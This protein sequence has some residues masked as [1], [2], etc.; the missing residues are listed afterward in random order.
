M[1]DLPYV[2]SPFAASI[3]LPKLAVA[4]GGLWN[5][6]VHI[7]PDDP[8]WEG[9]FAWMPDCCGEAHCWNPCT[10]CG[11]ERDPKQIS[12][13]R[14]LAECQPFEVYVRECCSSFSGD[15]E[16]IRERVVR[17]LQQSQGMAVETAFACG[18]CDGEPPEDPTT[19]CYLAMEGSEILTDCAVSATDALHSLVQSLCY[20]STGRG[21]IHAPPYVVSKWCQAGLVE[22]IWIDYA[23]E[24]WFPEDTFGP[25]RILVE[26][27]CGNVIVPGCGYG[28]CG[29]PGEPTQEDAAC[30]MWVYATS[31]V[32]ILSSDIRVIPDTPS[33]ALDRKTNTYIYEAV[34]TVAPIFAPCDGHSAILV[35][36]CMPE[37]VK[38]C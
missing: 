6:A 28:S 17:K 38:C 3:E 35:D 34:R 25:R 2:K 8:H 30:A 26:K 24:G 13:P 12:P 4:K 18:S 16:M 1:P 9:G 20:C 36:A 10:G 23:Q 14:E 27:I 33:E 11:E 29:P 21:M 22:T 32:C 5:S 15:P 37:S 31:M 19:G 7:T